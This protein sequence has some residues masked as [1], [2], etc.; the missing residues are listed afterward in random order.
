MTV[1]AVRSIARLY[2]LL[3]WLL[4]LSAYTT[5]VRAVAVNIATCPVNATLGSVLTLSPY[6]AFPSPSS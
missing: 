3:A 1:V 4:L 2:H 5:H 6:F